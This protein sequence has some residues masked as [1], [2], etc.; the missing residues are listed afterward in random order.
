MSSY[1]P[2]QPSPQPPG[3]DDSRPQAHH[4]SHP[5][6]EYQQQPQFALPA[7]WHYRY[8]PKRA[9]FFESRALRIWA[10]VVL[11]ALSGLLILAIV[12]Q[13]VGTEGF[14]VGLALAVLPVPLVVGAFLWIDRVE[15][16]PWSSV[17]FAFAWGACASTLVAIVANG[18]ATQLLA[19]AVT[20]TPGETDMM[21]ATFVAPPVEELAKGAGVLLLFLFRRRHFKGIVDGVVLAGVT[22]SG[23]AFTENILYLGRAFGEDQALGNDGPGAMTA[24]TFFVRIIVSPFAHP[25]FTCMLGI[26]LG[27]AA[28]SRRGQSRRVLA[29]IGGLLA[30]M[31]LH[32]LWNGSASLGPFGF[33]GVYALLMVPAFGG[34]IWLSVW[35]RNNELRA[36]REQLPVYA[37]AGWLTW[38]EPFAL[39]SMRARRLARDLAMR[40]QGPKGVDVMREYQAFATSLAFL[41]QRAAKG[42]AGP[43][44]ST[45]EQE[46]LHHLWQR[47][48]Q[49]RPL[50][51]QCVYAVPPPPGAGP[52]WGPGAGPGGPGGPGTGGPGGPGWGP[53]PAWGAA[54]PGGAVPA[55]WGRAP[56][57][58]GPGGHPAPAWGAGWGQPQPGPVQG[59]GAGWGGPQQ[60]GQWGGQG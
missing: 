25:L 8:R 3:R 11:L 18:F 24:G 30:G 45:R 28:M 4:H 9:A 2:P 12:Q 10:V 40:T 15:P 29:P 56:G 33:L 7:Q 51:A 13:Q 14:L 52:G 48:E 36:I 19:F 54:G 20:A 42:I 41:R 34:L 55:G 47:K 1:P 23:F 5:V 58:G 31:L 46:L 32:G 16:Q 44:F 57:P 50:L 53:A 26:G 39:S 38:P 49:V 43:D 22:A 59:Q 21:G 27:V 35:S 6:P 17:L 37:T 60:P